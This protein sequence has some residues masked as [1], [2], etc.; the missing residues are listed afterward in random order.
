MAF[1]PSRRCRSANVAEIDAPLPGSGT[2]AASVR[3]LAELRLRLIP[4]TLGRVPGVQ[5]LTD[6]Q[7]ASSLDYNAA[8]RSAAIRAFAFVMAAAFVLMLV[9]LGSMVIAATRVLLDLLSVGAAYGIMTAIF[10]HGWGVALMGTH[11]VRGFRHAVDAGL[12]AAR[13]QARGREPQPRR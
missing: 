13:R 5:A 9:S 8:L 4:Q 7:L 6:G 11:A 2:G 10:Q 1:I 3:A 12:Q